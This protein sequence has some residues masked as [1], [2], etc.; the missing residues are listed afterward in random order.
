MALFM[1]IGL[2]IFAILVAAVYGVFFSGLR[3]RET[4]Q[5]EA[6]AGIPREHAAMRLRRD[7]AG[8]V[9]PTGIL[10]GALTGIQGEGNNGAADRLTFYTT[11]AT[12]DEVP[13]A[14]ADT[15]AA[16]AARRKGPRRTTASKRC[17]RWRSSA[18]K[19]Q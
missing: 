7:F 18:S 19:W 11:S 10:A 15:C 14:I 3:L 13:S 8:I 9:S 1:I 12:V 16:A 17:W 5:R 6:E 4:A 2:A